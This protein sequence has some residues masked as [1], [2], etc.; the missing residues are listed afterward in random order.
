MSVSPVP[1][2]LQELGSRRFSFYPAI[3][4]LAHNEWL[5]RR[6]TWSEVVVVNANSGEEICIP[7]I[8]VGEVSI[9]DHPVVIV[10]LKRELEWKEGAVVPHRRA[11]IELPIAVNDSAR[12][13]AHPH[14]P[15]PVVSIRL[16]PPAQKRAGRKIAV[17]IML[18]SVGCLVLADFARQAQNHPRPP[19]SQLSASDTYASVVRTLGTPASERTLPGS[20]GQV[21][22]ALAYPSRQFIVVLMSLNH[23]EF[24]YAGAIDARGRVLNAVTLPDRTSA[25]G[26]LRAMPAQR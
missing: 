5:Y 12:Q 18:G 14:A 6:A 7:R 15:A 4:N 19:F 24:H 13:H 11:V 17:A 10:G 23:S 25:G 3:L 21:Y 1:I 8:F 9:V 16:E 26:L 22:R 20:G 2:P